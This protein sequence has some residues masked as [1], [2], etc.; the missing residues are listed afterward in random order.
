MQKLLLGLVEWRTLWRR[1]S[2]A[3]PVLAV[4]SV[5]APAQQPI[6]SPFEIARA[7]NSQRNFVQASVYLKILW[8]D[9]NIPRGAFN[10]DACGYRCEADVFQHNLD[11]EPGLEA[12][13]KLTGGEAC[14]YL[15]FKQN[16]KR[17]SFLGY[18]DHDFNK[19]EMSTHRVLNK[20]LFVR[21]QQGSGTG[22]SL[23]GE[24][25]YR[26]G[27]DGVRP[28]LS[29][30][31][32]GHTFPWPNGL[33]RE[34]KTIA[35]H[36]SN[37]IDVTYN[38]KYTMLDYLNDKLNVW[39]TN[40]HR[41][42][43]V[44]DEQQNK[45]VFVAKASDLSEDEVAAI[46]NA[47]TDSDESTPRVGNTTFPAKKQ[48]IGGGYQIFLKSNLTLLKRIARGPNSVQKRWLREVLREADDTPEKK[49]LVKALG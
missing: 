30:W 4:L 33:G 11:D 41:V 9:L 24:N 34:F 22:F 20:L 14:R 32:S 12:V 38:V 8:E 3:L 29:Y 48:F 47:E 13:L 26:V 2:L 31:F 1:A 5:N 43:Y 10:S 7:I 25:V 44:W 49:E 21:G 46:A 42:R 36:K 23:Y 6:N 45:Y 18:V 16:R 27:N 37:Q 15:I 39:L 17:W 35:S 19:Y 28:V 40:T